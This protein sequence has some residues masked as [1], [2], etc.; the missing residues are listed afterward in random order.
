M[1]MTDDEIIRECHRELRRLRSV[2]RE[3]Q[4]EMSEAEVR[5]RRRGEQAIAHGIMERYCDDCVALYG[6][7][8]QCLECPIHNARKM[9]NQWP[10]LPVLEKTT[11][12]DE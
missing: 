6:G 1:A 10:L 2:V 4:E 11:T 5:G 12:E 7:K 3:L 9:L 8:K